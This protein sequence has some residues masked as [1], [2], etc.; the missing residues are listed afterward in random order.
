MKVLLLFGWYEIISHYICLQVCF[1]T[2]KIDF[3]S[4]FCCQKMANYVIYMES[5]NLVIS[6]NMISVNKNMIENGLEI[7]SYTIYTCCKQMSFRG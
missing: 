7:S 5:N 2:C 4:H 6:S 1:Y 3:T